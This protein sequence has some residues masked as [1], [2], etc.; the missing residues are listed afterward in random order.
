LTEVDAL[1]SICRHIRGNAPFLAYGGPGTG[2][3]RI[4][5]FAIAYLLHMKTDRP[6]LVCAAGSTSIDKVLAVHANF[7][8]IK[9]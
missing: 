1:Q 2:K 6:F 5:T 4:F 8:N 7:I 9:L 3:T